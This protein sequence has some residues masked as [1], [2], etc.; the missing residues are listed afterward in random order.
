VAGIAPHLVCESY[1]LQLGVGFP[2]LIIDIG[3]GVRGLYPH[4]E[5][6]CCARQFL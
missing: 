6:V 3:P 5:V 1:L 4:V 2:G